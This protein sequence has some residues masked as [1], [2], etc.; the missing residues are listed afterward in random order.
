LV[1]NG[2]EPKEAEVRGSVEENHGNE[3][4]HPKEKDWGF[5]GIQNKFV[6][7]DQGD[8]GEHVEEDRQSDSGLVSSEDLGRVWE[9]DE[10]LPSVSLE[11]FHF[12]QEC[13]KDLKRFL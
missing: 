5:C 6:E 7:D 8:G 1:L 4:L 11:K 12:C 9:T 3:E 2:R 13:V 10:G